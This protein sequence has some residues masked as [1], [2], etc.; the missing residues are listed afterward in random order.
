[1]HPISVQTS[2]Q[3][4]QLETEMEPVVPDQYYQNQMPESTALHEVTQS[5]RRRRLDSTLVSGI[6]GYLAGTGIAAFAS[7]TA[8]SLSITAGVIGTALSALGLSA[9]LMTHRAREN[10]S[11][12]KFLVKNLLVAGMVGLLGYSAATHNEC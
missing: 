4:L 12:Y 2:N 1:M 6:H 10:E 11:G 3:S 8:S 7:P 5:A 9:F